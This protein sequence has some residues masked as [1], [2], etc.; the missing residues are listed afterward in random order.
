MVGKSTLNERSEE[1]WMTMALY[2][3]SDGTVAGVLSR[4]MATTEARA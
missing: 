4:A 1:A 2:E 3:R